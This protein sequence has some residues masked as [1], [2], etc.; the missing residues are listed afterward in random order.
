MVL[1]AIHSIT[2]PPRSTDRYGYLPWIYILLFQDKE[3]G[4]QHFQYQ[5]SWSMTLMSLVIKT[6]DSPDEDG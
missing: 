5:G 1:E 3:V 6:P 2:G 4:E